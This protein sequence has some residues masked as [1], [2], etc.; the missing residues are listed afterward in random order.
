MNTNKKKMEHLNESNCRKKSIVTALW[1][2]LV[3]RLARNGTAVVTL[4]HQRRMHSTLTPLHQWIYPTT[5]VN[6][7]RG[8]RDVDTASESGGAVPHFPGVRDSSCFSLAYVV[9]GDSRIFFDFLHFELA[10]FE[11]SR[12]HSKYV[13]KTPITESN[14]SL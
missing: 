13:V 8:S 5:I 11:F 7:S 6:D 14:G 4:T 12:R 2:S 10:V 9:G 3:E 1:C